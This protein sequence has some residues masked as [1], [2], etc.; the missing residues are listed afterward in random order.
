MASHEC[1]SIQ[2]LSTQLFVQQLIQANNIEHQMSAVLALCWGNPQVNGST[3]IFTET[4]SY[5][6]DNFT[7]TGS[8]PGFR[9][10][11]LQSHQMITLPLLAAHLVLVITTCSATSGDKVGIMMT[12]VFSLFHHFC[13]YWL[14]GQQQDLSHLNLTRNCPQVQEKY[15]RCLF[16]GTVSYDVIMVW[17]SSWRMPN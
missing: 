13:I 1:N 8:T 6:D 15:Y 17:M 7:I 3:V 14:P 10:Y 11:N 9:Y 16:N 5:P 4:E 12:Y 2:K